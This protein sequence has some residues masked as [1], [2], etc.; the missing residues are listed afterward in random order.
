MKIIEIIKVPT[1][2]TNSIAYIIRL[3]DSEIYKVP[4]AFIDKTKTNEWLLNIKNV[5]ADF[6]IKNI[7]YKNIIGIGIYNK[8]RKVVLSI[9]IDPFFVRR[10]LATYLYDYIEKDNNLILSPSDNLLSDGEKFWENRLQK[11]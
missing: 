11:K 2:F 3:K 5:I 6:K 1:G 8:I 9:K 10:G 4:G 7:F